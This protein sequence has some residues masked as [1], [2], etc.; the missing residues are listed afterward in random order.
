MGSI[1]RRMR[2]ILA[3]AFVALY[4]T[5][6]ILGILSISLSFIFFITSFKE[7]C[8]LYWPFKFSTKKETT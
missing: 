3:I 8:P 1:D 5:D 7:F 2:A 4:Y 6:I